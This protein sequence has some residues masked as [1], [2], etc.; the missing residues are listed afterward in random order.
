MR[1]P[2]NLFNE[3]YMPLLVYWFDVIIMNYYAIIVAFHS[4]VP[5]D[6]YVVNLVFTIR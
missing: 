1:K 3:P 2:G 4:I 5:Y 6:S